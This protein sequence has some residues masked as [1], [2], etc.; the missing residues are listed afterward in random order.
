MKYEEI[1]S[2][3]SGCPNRYLEGLWQEK[4]IWNVTTDFLDTNLGES[5]SHSC[6]EVDV[7]Q[8]LTW[9][10]GHDIYNLAWYRPNTHPVVAGSVSK[11]DFGITQNGNQLISIESKNWEP[12]YKPLS[13]YQVDTQIISRFRYLAAP[14][15]ILIISKLNLE[16]ADTNKI[17]NLL[18]QNPVTLIRTGRK[19]QG[20]YDT[21][22]YRIIKK[23]LP[24]IITRILKLDPHSKKRHKT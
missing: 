7:K 3:P 18:K 2:T 14:N 15:R 12:N 24:P 22:S 4:I 6:Q 21:K 20:I 11:P 19:T 5:Q 8:I 9:E 16:P 23:C 1:P 13:I 17:W 10:H